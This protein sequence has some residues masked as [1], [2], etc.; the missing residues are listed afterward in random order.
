ML[1][2]L[3]AS[4]ALAHGSILKGIVMIVLG[5]LLGTVGTDINSGTPRFNLGT[6][7]LPTAYPSLRSVR[8]IY[9]IAEIL[10]GL[11]VER[12]RDVHQTKSQI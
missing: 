10:R 5:L 8:A 12:D 3:V 7:D 1:L 9:A 2:G 4:I 6:I 11:E